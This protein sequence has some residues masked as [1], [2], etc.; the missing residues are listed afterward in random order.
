MEE[1]RNTDEG[2]RGERRNTEEL[3][4]ICRRILLIR[5]SKQAAKSKQHGANRPKSK[6]LER[7]SRKQAARQAARS[8]LQEASI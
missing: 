6:Q 5:S 8:R 7:S 1:R 4:R 2:R 3:Q